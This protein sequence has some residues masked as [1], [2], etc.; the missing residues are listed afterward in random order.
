MQCYSPCVLAPLTADRANVV[1]YSG[2]QIT[3][4]IP[5]TWTESSHWNN[6]CLRTE[7]N[8]YSRLSTHETHRHVD[9]NPDFWKSNS[10]SVSPKP[11]KVINTSVK[12]LRIRL[13]SMLNLEIATFL[14]NS[15][16]TVDKPWIVLVALCCTFSNLMLQFRKCGERGPC[17]KKKIIIW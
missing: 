10:E 6:P 5:C 9:L 11:L 15:F 1:E 4:P 13:F 3:L 14:G 2:T 7:N 16:W 17:L 12:S 8:I